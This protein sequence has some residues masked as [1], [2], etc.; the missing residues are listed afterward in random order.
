MGMTFELCTEGE[1]Y[2]ICQGAGGGYGDVLERDPE[3]VMKDLREDLMSHENAVDIYKVVYDK[4]QLV[5]DVEATAELRSA[6]RRARLARS[7][8]YDEFVAEWVTP[9]P[10]K[11]LTYFGSWNDNREIWAQNPAINMTVKMDADKLQGFYMPNPKDLRIAELEGEV[12]ALKSKLEA[13]VSA[14]KK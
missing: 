8:P 7:K 6:E 5:V 2:M 1:V 11:H 14:T 10:P 4:E 12:G 3:L 9:E 13:C